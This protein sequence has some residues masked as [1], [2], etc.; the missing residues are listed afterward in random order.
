MSGDTLFVFGLLLVTVLLFV[1]DRVRLDVVALA[2]ILVLMLSGLLTPAESLAGFGDPVVLLLAGLFVV[3]EGLYR[4]GIAFAVGD[5]LM[6]VA[7]TSELR[8]LVMLMLVVA[9]LSAFMS[10]TGAVAIFIPIVLS[11]AARAGISPSRLLLPI[12]LASLIGGMLTLIGTPPNLVVSIQLEREGLAPFGFFSFTPIGALVLMAGIGYML[13]V[14]R[15]LLP[16][17]VTGNKRRRARRSLVELAEAY[18]I[19]GQLRRLRLGSDSPLSGHSVEQAMLLTRYQAMVVGIERDGLLAPALSNT[20]LNAG[21]VLL[22]VGADTAL[23]TLCK[24]EKLTEVP[25]RDYH[26]RTVTKELGLAEVLLT[27]NSDLIGHSLIEVNFREHHDLTVLGVLRM[28]KPLEGEFAR[29]PLAFGDSLL[30]AGGWKDISRIQEGHDD[31]LVLSLPREMDE[32]APNRGKAR[33]ALLILAVMLLLMTF[34]LVP[35]VTAVLLAALAMVVTGCVSMNN[36]YHSLNA[37]SLVLIAGMLP[38]ATALEKTGGIDLVAG[39][40]VS[41]LGDFGPFA[42]MAGLFVLTSVFSQFISNT[43]TTVLV[44]PVAVA[45]AAELGVSPYPILMT[46]AIAASTAFATPVASPVNTLVLG[47]GGYRFNDFVKVGVPL[48]VLAM[49]VTLLAV[50]ALFPL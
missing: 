2:V 13:L 19:R 12:A 20:R 15:H 45:A 46:V 5:W 26:F 14:G 38:M 7:G 23:T 37:Q 28:G 50:P 17:R 21:D 34:N 48:Q 22:V 10:S 27:P 41:G 4:T 24:R 1:S 40:L 11:L 29:I 32:I 31:F 18:G 6:R 16:N 3:G 30:V 25:L 39:G 43:A 33:H 49:A 47:P 35:G 8:L 9:G 36:A 42:L 44:A